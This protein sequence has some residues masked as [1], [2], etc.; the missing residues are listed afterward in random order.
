M[1]V[2][3]GSFLWIP[4]KVVFF[5][6]QSSFVD[7]TGTN[8]SWIGIT[9][10]VFGAILPV[11]ELLSLKI[12]TLYCKPVFHELREKRTRKRGSGTQ[13]SAPLIQDTNLNEEGDV[14][15]TQLDR[16]NAGFFSFHLSLWQFGLL[17]AGYKGKITHE[18]FWQLT[19]N[20]DPRNLHKKFQ[21]S[22]ATRT[23]E[24]PYSSGWILFQ[25]VKLDMIKAIS[26][27][28]LQNACMVFAPLIIKEFVVWIGS[29]CY[30]F[31]DIARPLCECGSA[32][33]CIRSSE[34]SPVMKDS[35][36]FTWGVQLSL[37]LFLF[38]VTMC[39]AQGMEMYWSRSL[40]MKMR[41]TM[42]TTVYRRILETPLQVRSQWSTG[43]VYTLITQNAEIMYLAGYMTAR[44]CVAPVVICF[45][46]WIAIEQAGYA[47]PLVTK[48]EYIFDL[49]YKLMHVGGSWCYDFVC[50]CCKKNYTETTDQ[51]KR[52]GSTNSAS[53][54]T[55]G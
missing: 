39:L 55:Y 14:S 18:T 46:L 5:F 29:P 8:A 50:T 45:G 32:S 49:I 27:V 40:G 23:P 51:T 44:S 43:A 4:F 28:M 19:S 1:I 9:A 34:R 24:Q 21:K 10:L 26:W 13:E 42:M 11:I 48:C 53:N 7:E 35:R 22:E 16:V 38:T 2:I 3:G 33:S 17:Y 47:A 37:G 41:N 30:D 15:H 25:V 36:W 20:D 6:S 12:L 52:D 54:Y 31:D